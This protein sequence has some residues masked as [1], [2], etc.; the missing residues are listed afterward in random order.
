MTAS[1][2]SGILF[3]FAFVAICSACGADDS[4]GG[5]AAAGSSGSGAASGSAGSGGGGSGATG[6]GGSGGSSASAGSG[7][8][9]CTALAQAPR[10]TL[11]DFESGQVPGSDCATCSMGFRTADLANISLVSPGASGTANAAELDFGPSQTF[12]FQRKKR[13]EYFDGSA[14]Y[15]PGLANALE[16]WV[17]I[18]S[19]SALLA[20]SGGR[21]FSVYTY[22]WKPGDPWV[23]PNDTGGN[24]TDSQMHGYGSIRFDPSAAGQFIRVVMTTSA[25]Q[26]S[27]ASY[28]FYAMRATVEELEFFA[29]LRQIQLVWHPASSSG[30]TE[31]GFDELSLVTLPP[32]AALCPDFHAATV[33]AAGG[34]VLAPFELVNPT[35]QER[36]YRAFVSSVIGVDRQTLETAL[37][38]TDDNTAPGT[39]QDAVGSDG[40]LWAVEL[41]ADDGSGKPTGSSLVASGQQITLAPGQ[42]F[43][44]VV[45]HHVTAGMLGQTVT[46]THGT[47]SYSVKRDTL[48]TSIV[49]WDPDDPGHGSDAVVFGG[50]NAD[51]SHA[52]PPGFPAQTLPPAGWRSSDVPPDQVGA[53]FVS[54][55]RLN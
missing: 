55:L 6:G 2:Q 34:D 4:G 40:G 36:S 8:A 41:F 51:T 37:H 11:A 5:G 16:Y 19:G 43:R 15:S 1:G 23:G 20:A 35:S 24:L 50:S 33:P 31:L 7:G 28:H 22:H 21:T 47:K 48:T 49:F 38:D 53:Y 26:Q 46:A 25:F 42:S 10:I 9:A 27:R 44:G 29:S 52:A 12:F 39:L 14:T 13:P 54:V 45:V 32:T 18:P 17:R 30:P 3:A